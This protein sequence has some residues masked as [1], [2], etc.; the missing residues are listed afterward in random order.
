MPVLCEAG[1]EVVNL[2]FPGQPHMILVIAIE[3][4]VSHCR[5]TGQLE[6]KNPPKS[7][8]FSLSHLGTGIPV[9]QRS[10]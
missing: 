5:P 10:T 2:Q 4:R 7:G 1:L 3:D 6:A 8:G 9:F